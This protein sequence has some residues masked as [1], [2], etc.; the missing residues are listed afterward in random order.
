MGDPGKAGKA[1]GINQPEPEGG[2]T[3]EG[4]DARV[5]ED[6]AVGTQ[7]AERPQPRKPATKQAEP[8]G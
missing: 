1:D 4:Q 5:R 6:S 8:S 3:E 7:Q 2:R